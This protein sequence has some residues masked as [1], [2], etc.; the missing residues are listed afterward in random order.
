MVKLPVS[1]W[2]HYVPV[3]PHWLALREEQPLHPNVPI[4][5]AHHHLWD[6]SYLRYM[7]EDLLADIETGGHDI[8]AT[9]HVQCR[10]MHREGGDEALRPVGETEFVNGVAAM[11]ASGIYGR[12][13]ACA[14]IIGF[15]DLLMGDRVAR[16]I[17]AHLRTAGERFRGLRQIS[18]FSPDPA[19][20]AGNPAP[21]GLTADMRFREGFG[22]LAGYGLSFDA[23]AYHT[24]LHEL[25][26]LAARFPETPIVVGHYG[27]PLGT[28]G[29][30]DRAEVFR[31]WR[32]AIADL[33]R[34]PNTFLKLGGLGMHVSGFNWE[35]RALPPSSEELAAAWR[36][37]FD[38]AMDSFG[39]QRCMFESNFPVDK[40]C[41]G[42]GV[43][44]NA[45]KRLAAPL[46]EA[47]RERLL[48]GTAMEVYRLALHPAG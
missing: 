30:S 48:G 22:R 1:H 45:C 6:R 18:A 36:P 16:V 13:R 46:G 5:D 7:F 41:F 14:G 12:L 40:G 2:A 39:P 11:C 23:W 25:A 43:F 44:W 35:K 10:S 33:A 8:R 17:D 37:Y 24:Q 15:A 34:R 31:H 47:E 29:F 21:P 9:V 42:Y 28:G 26:D 20:S 38:V 19:V 4:V 3:R 32:L 27:G